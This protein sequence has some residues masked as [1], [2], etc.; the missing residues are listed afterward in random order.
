MLNALRRRLSRAMLADP[1]YTFLFEAGPP[2]EVVVIDCETTGLNPRKD[3]IITVAA[4]HVRGERILTSACFEAVART[5]RKSHPDAIKVH[6]IFDAEARA[7]RPMRQILPELLRFIGGR[8]IV[9]YYTDFDVRMLDRYLTRLLNIRLPNP[10]IDVSALYYDRKY[11]GAPDHLMIDLSF[12]SILRDL[13][14]PPLAQHDALN[15]ALMTAMIYLQLRDM[16]RRGA[17]IARDRA[18]AVVGLGAAG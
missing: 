5:E 10:R 7:G 13:G 15:D 16:A 1:A 14:I 9:G 11:K 8:P 3:E 2:D 18:G 4:I 17:R 12:A 6:R